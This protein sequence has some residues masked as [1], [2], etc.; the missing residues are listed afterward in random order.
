MECWRGGSLP[1]GWRYAQG[2]VFWP[3]LVIHFLCYHTSDYYGLNYILLLVAGNLWAALFVGTCRKKFTST[4]SWR[5]WSQTL[6]CPQ[7]SR[8]S[9][10]FAKC[11]DQSP[12]PSSTTWT[13]RPELITGLCTTTSRHGCKSCNQKDELINLVCVMNPRQLFMTSLHLYLTTMQ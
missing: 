10:S 3:P 12:S 5:A 1:S 2:F 11:V 8:C 9:M 4:R 7:W 6:K 13:L